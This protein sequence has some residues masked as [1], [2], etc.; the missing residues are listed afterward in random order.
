MK[1]RIN[2][3]LERIR[4]SV[5]R[6]FEALEKKLDTNTLTFPEFLEHIKS[7]EVCQVVVMPNIRI[8][9][10]N[11][12]V[13]AHVPGAVTITGRSY[14]TLYFS[15]DSGGKNL[16]DCRKGHIKTPYSLQPEIEEQY[17]LQNILTAYQELIELQL[18]IPGV[19]FGMVLYGPGG[20][21][22]KDTTLL[23]SA[24]AIAKAREKG[25]RPFPPRG[26]I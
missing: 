13:A 19:T 6:G 5:K 8:N 16:K 14:E 24:R 23:E 1:D 18:T 21:M 7:G 2:D 11:I 4:R 22:D 17:R 26:E 20:L 12:P 15:Y 3:G 9:C 10:S 25:I